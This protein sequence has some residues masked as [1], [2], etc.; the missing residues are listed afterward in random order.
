MRTPQVAA[1]PV[2]PPGQVA[3]RAAVMAVDAVI[4]HRR[5]LDEAFA[6]AL[7][8]PGAKDMAGRD[9]A[10]ARLIATTTLRHHGQIDA[11]FKRFLEKP[12][13]DQCGRLKSILAT[14][15]AQLLFLGTPAHA[16]LSQAVDIVR[17]DHEARRFD[18]LANAVLRRTASDGAAI[19]G[20]FDGVWLDMPEWLWKRWEAAYGTPVARAMAAASL[21]EPALDLSVKGAAQAWAE[22]LTG[23]ALPNGS[24]RVREAGRIEELPGFAEGGWWVQDAAAALPVLLFG[25]VQGL[26][27]ADLCAAPGGK[28]AQLAARGAKVTAVDQSAKRLERLSANLARLQ[29]EATQVAADI[30]TFVAEPSHQSAFDAVL[31]D[32][33]CSATGTIRRHPDL[34]RNKAESEIARLAGVQA[35]LI[36]AAGQAVKPGGLLVY[37]TCS[38]EPEEGEGVVAGFLD[39]HPAFEVVPLGARDTAIPA[40]FITP[41]GYLR[42]RPDLGFGPDPIMAGMD[43]FFAARLRRQVQ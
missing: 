11:M 7:A 29:L 6:E 24:V 35:A 10:F 36:A 20:S 1:V 13:P 25:D 31:L 43:G 34:L 12:L 42:T 14:S 15:A 2:Q 22:R 41:D 33:P 27:V 17:L 30:A 40:S 19:L 21:Q 8:K 23:V 5:T 4:R 3:R 37:C 16:V 18:K 9:R 38:L 28:A 32:A 26:A 39:A